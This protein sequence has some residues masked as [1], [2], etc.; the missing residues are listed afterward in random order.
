MWYQCESANVVPINA[1]KCVCLCVCMNVYAL[2]S[3]FYIFMS[4][5][6]YQNMLTLSTFMGL[7]VTWRRLVVDCLDFS[8]ALGV[9]LRSTWT[10]YLLVLT[11]FM[12]LWVFSLVHLGSYINSGYMLPHDVLNEKLEKR[13]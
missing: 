1:Y 2:I 11:N 8:R 5:V 6:I 13:C 4:A 3:Y 12:C 9:L 10:Q 7:E